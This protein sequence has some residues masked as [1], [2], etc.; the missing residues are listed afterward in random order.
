VLKAIGWLLFILFVVAVVLAIITGLTAGTVY[1][2]G[3]SDKM[4]SIVFFCYSLLG[5]ATIFGVMNC[6]EERYR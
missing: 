3:L 4:Q 6:L 1:M 5:A 2:F